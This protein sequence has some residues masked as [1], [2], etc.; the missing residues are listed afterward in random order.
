MF[1]GSLKMFGGPLKILD[2]PSTS[3]GKGAAARPPGKGLDTLE[4]ILPPSCPQSWIKINGGPRQGTQ[5]GRGLRSP[6]APKQTF[7]L[8]SSEMCPLLGAFGRPPT[9]CQYGI[10][11]SGLKC[12]LAP[13]QVSKPGHAT[14]LEAQWNLLIDFWLQKCMDE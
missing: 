13:P 14:G 4:K 8:R 2:D 12:M 9:P 5:N 1:C 10:V 6:R 11:P 7:Y 3:K